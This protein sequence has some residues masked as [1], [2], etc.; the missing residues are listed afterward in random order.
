MEITRFCMFEILYSM[1]HSGEIS[2]KFM[3]DMETCK[4]TLELFKVFGQFL[5]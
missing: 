3:I 4:H 1:L 5:A 2:S